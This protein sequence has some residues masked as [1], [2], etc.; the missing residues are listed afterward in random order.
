MHNRMLAQLLAQQA[1]DKKLAAANDELASVRDRLDQALE[2]LTAVMSDVG[3]N[4]RDA[5]RD[6]FNH[7]R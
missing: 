3:G 2:V 1:F 7:V 5:H 4:A 6:K